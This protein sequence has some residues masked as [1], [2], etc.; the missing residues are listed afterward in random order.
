MNAPARD[1]SDFGIANSAEAALLHPEKAKSLG[2]PERVLSEG[3]DST[4]KF[5]KGTVKSQAVV[6]LTLQWQ[7]NVSFR[8]KTAV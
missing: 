1:P 8:K 5:L 4:P 7:W 3:S 6:N 2:A